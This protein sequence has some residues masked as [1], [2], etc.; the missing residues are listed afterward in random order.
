MTKLQDLVH[1]TEAEVDDMI[2][3][4][5]K[6]HEEMNELITTVAVDNAAKTVVNQAC[7]K[8]EKTFPEKRA[9]LKICDFVHCLDLLAKD[10]MKVTCFG[11]LLADVS[12]LI[13]FSCVS[14]IDGIRS[15]LVRTGQ[16]PENCGTVRTY[17][18]T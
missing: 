4:M 16:L 11:S 14:T 5:A 2:K 1:A 9:I 6:T 7:N 15:D 8:Y 12:L 3:V 10:S 18:E 13:K 17:S